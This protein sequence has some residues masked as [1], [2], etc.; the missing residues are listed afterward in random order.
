MDGKTS[1]SR[2]DLQHVVFG[3]KLKLL[4]DAVDLGHGGFLEGAFGP[5]ENAARVSQGFIQEQGI[6][7]I[8]QVIMSGDIDPAALPGVLVEEVIGLV[9][10]RLQP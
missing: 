4:A 3:G 7:V 2:A 8:A 10:R 5:L 6:E 1:P 9:K